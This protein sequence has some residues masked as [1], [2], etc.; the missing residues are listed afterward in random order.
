MRGAAAAASRTVI[1]V[2]RAFLNARNPKDFAF[3]EYN[4]AIREYF[5]QPLECHSKPAA[6]IQMLKLIP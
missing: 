4:V 5:N 6:A 2:S 1:I 3:F